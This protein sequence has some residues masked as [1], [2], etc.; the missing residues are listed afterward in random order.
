MSIRP[1]PHSAP[2]D[3]ILVVAALAALGACAGPSR[4]G[5]GDRP[6]EREAFTAAPQIYSPNGEPLSGGALGQ[7]SCQLATEYWFDRADSNHDGRLDQGEFMAD[8]RAQFARMDL[9]HLGALTADV[10]ERTREPFRPTD[11]RAPPP[12]GVDPVMSADANFDLKV[13]PEEFATQAQATFRHLDANHDG[14][15]DKTELAAICAE[16]ARQQ[17]FRHHRQGGGSGPEG[18]PQRRGGNL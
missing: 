13:T 6:G 15:I 14:A 16:Q 17:Q 8:S 1:F 2:L 18:A 11:R 4:H 12:S 5:P 9:D 10:L 3:A 7:P